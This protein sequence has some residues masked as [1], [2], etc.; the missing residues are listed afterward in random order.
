[1]CVLNSCRDRILGDGSR[2]RF[3]IIRGARVGDMPILLATSASHLRRQ[4]LKLEIV[5]FRFSR[6]QWWRAAYLSFGTSPA[7]VELD[8]RNGNRG[9]GQSFSALRIGTCEFPGLWRPEVVSAFV[10]DVRGPLTMDAETAIEAP[11]DDEMVPG[12]HGGRPIAESSVR[13]CG[14]GVVVGTGEWD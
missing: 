2:I 12:V 3:A 5:V 7:F 11:S 6:P 10:V 13:S 4:P 14:L 9:H 1:M 8:L